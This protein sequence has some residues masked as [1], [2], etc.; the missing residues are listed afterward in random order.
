MLSFS[1]WA[2][3][4]FLRWPNKI[5]VGILKIC[6]WPSHCMCLSITTSSIRY[7][8]SNCF[9]SHVDVAAYRVYFREGGRGGFCPPPPP[10]PPMKV[11]VF[12]PPQELVELTYWILAMHADTKAIVGCIIYHWVVWAAP[13]NFRHYL[14]ALPEAIC[15]N[16]P[17]HMLL[18]VNNAFVH[19]LW[20]DYSVLV[21]GCDVSEP[22]SRVEST[23]I[24]YSAH[25]DR[26]Q[27]L[28]IHYRH[29]TLK[30]IE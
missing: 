10:P 13:L 12:A 20:R 7:C 6:P 17:W 24:F 11:K 21:K 9:L 18:D 25:I 2:W 8:T 28:R 15:W 27:F 23:S 3:F 16:K 29:N 22:Y 19:L 5:H 14:L 30:M 1:T 4:D 26:V